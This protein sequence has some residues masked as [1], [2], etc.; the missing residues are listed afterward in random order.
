[1]NLQ[2][3][4][5]EILLRHGDYSGLVK[6]RL[7]QIKLHSIRL[8]YILSGQIRSY[9][10]IFIDSLTS[11]VLRFFWGSNIPNRDIAVTHRTFS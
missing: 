3:A 6:V 4:A 2:P 7:N 10:V 11:L 9:E 8:N 1:M 5:D